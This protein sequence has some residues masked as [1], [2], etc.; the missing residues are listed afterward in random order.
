MRKAQLWTKQSS[1]RA[2]PSLFWSPA[3]SSSSR[4]PPR[5]PSCSSTKS[6]RRSVARSQQLQ[7][8]AS[9]PVYS[10]P[11]QTDWESW[12]PLVSGHH[13]RPLPA[14]PQQQPARQRLSLQADLAKHRETF[15]K[16][17]VQRR[18]TFHYCPSNSYQ[19]H[20]EDRDDHIYE[21]IED[22]DDSEDDGDDHSFLS[23]ISSER[24][25]NLRLYGLT[26]WDYGNQRS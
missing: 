1:P 2:A 22:E 12:A 5:S 24:R 14:L 15:V 26:D 4:S 6:S 19:S 21:E 25:R 3:S 20:K 8:S 13:R 10:S 16:R 17:E 9:F 7:H 11:K 18:Q 23:L